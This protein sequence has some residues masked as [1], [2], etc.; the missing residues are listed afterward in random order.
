MQ[1]LSHAAAQCLVDHLMLLDT[2][3]AAKALR[4]DFRRIMIA[5]PCKIADGDPGIGNGFLDELLDVMGGHGHEG[6][7]LLIPHII[8]EPARMGPAEFTYRY[9]MALP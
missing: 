1:R 2:R 4:D 3:L 7:L 5:I 6:L 9:D 8:R